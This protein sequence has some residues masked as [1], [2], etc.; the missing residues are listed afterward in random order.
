ML[1]FC[2]EITIVGAL[3]WACSLPE[4][5]EHAADNG[6]NMSVLMWFYIYEVYGYFE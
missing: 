1:Y 2:V 4:T 3:S 6:M 5:E